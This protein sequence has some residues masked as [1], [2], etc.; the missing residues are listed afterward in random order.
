MLLRRFTLPNAAAETLCLP[1]FVWVGPLLLQLT[2][3]SQR[4]GGRE[5]EREREVYNIDDGGPQGKFKGN[6]LVIS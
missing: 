3:S 4:E 5:E 6:L 1:Q 2:S